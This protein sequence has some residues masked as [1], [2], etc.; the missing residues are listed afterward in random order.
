MKAHFNALAKR[1]KAKHLQEHPDYHYQPRKPGEK[2]RRRSRQQVACSIHDGTAVNSEDVQAQLSDDDAIQEAETQAHLTDDDSQAE[3]VHNQVTDNNAVDSEE[4]HSQVTDNV[5]VQPD[6]NQASLELSTTE[7]GNTMF[8]L[9]HTDMTDENLAFLLTAYNNLPP[10][11][12]AGIFVVPPPPHP[13][14]ILHHE[15]TAEA[16]EA[17]ETEMALTFF[18]FDAYYAEEEANEAETPSV[19]PD[20]NLDLNPNSPANLAIFDAE[21]HLVAGAEVECQKAL[22]AETANEA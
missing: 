18:D 5:V 6:V 14:P 21:W 2:K 13:V 17:R 16:K 8:E 9:G 1:L 22:D 20:P 10:P 4:A 12:T 11:P 15:E 19:F 3:L 7:G